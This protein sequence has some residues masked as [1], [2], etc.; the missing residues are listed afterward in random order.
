MPTIASLC[1]V[2]KN[3]R[4][5]KSESDLFSWKTVRAS[6]MKSEIALPGI[7]SFSGESQRQAKVDQGSQSK[8]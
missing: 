8:R 1:R 5:N 2:L 3:S 6:R 4:R 7:E